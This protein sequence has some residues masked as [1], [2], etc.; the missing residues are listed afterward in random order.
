M[1]NMYCNADYQPNGQSPVSSSSKPISG[2]ISLPNRKDVAD[3]ST[4]RPLKTEE[5]PN[6][7]A[8]FRNAARNAI[9]AGMFLFLSVA[10][11]GDLKKRM[12][13]LLI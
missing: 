3:F 5:I 2:K 12:F 6:I 8:D 4:P 1:Y 10:T 9:D 13:I 7:V 11:Y